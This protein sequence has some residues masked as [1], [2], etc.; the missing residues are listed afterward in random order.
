MNNSLLL[1]MTFCNSQG[2][3][4]TVYNRQGGQMYKLIHD[5]NYDYNMICPF[6]VFEPELAVVI[7]L[8]LMLCL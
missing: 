5:C 7:S 4:A 3:V 6:V 1:K 8:K 2:K